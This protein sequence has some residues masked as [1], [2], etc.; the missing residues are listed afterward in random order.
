MLKGEIPMWEKVPIIRGLAETERF[1]LSVQMYPYDGLANPDLT[2][3]KRLNSCNSLYFHAV[4]SHAERATD[5]TDHILCRHKSRHT[6]RG[7]KNDLQNRRLRAERAR[8]AKR[9]TSESAVTERPLEGLQPFATVHGIAG[10]LQAQNILSQ[11][12]GQ[13]LNGR[14][15]SDEH[16]PCP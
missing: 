3:S 11:N 13:G 8:S 12:R 1:E 7:G 9:A 10:Q 14:E 6:S 4:M 2:I 15:G 5:A 16:H